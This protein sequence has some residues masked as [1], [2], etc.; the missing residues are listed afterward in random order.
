MKIY[1]AG[2]ISGL[3]ISEV[4]RKFGSAAAELRDL[5]FE[6][7][8]PVDMSGWGLSWRAYLHI[9]SE[10]LQSGEIDAVYMLGDWLQSKG[11]ALERSW[12]HLNGIP[13]YY[14]NTGWIQKL[15]ERAERPYDAM[16]DDQGRGGGIR[17]N[18]GRGPGRHLVPGE[19][20]RLQG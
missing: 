19:L 18:E 8:N 14:E 13:V 10:I 20:P 1:I 15:K 11:A 2:P 5:G 12:A 17:R 6:P 7:V 16:G 4:E 3:P 9:T